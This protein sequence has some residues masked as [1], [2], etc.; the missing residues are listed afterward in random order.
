VILRGRGISK[1]QG[2]GGVLLS[3]A[4]VSFL[5]G[6]NPATGM[7]T[8]PPLNG[9]SVK[10]AIFAFPRGKGSTVGSYVLLEMKRNDTL[11]AAMINST[12]EPIVATGAVMAKVP[13]V[14]CIDLSLLKDGDMALVNGDTGTVELPDIKEVHVVSCVVQDEDKYLILKRSALVGT[15][16]G[17]WAAV[18]GFV[19][20]DET[21][22]QCA[23]KELRE[24]TTLELEVARSGEVIMA[25]SDDTVW[26]IHPYLFK[27]TA[28]EVRIDWE[29][30]EFRW[31]RLEELKGLQTV[32]GLERVLKGLL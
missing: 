24:E 16:K 7:L 5:G 31:L 4:A 23:I 9:R 19:E 2:K 30:T 21:P 20:P 15:F 27:A 10:D 32:P 14:D 1:G 22:D 28:P 6:V 12:A 18:S 29:H 13:L 3:E 25:R 17:H 11:P 8:E 26:V